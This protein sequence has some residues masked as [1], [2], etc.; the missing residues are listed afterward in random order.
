MKVSKGVMTVI[1][2]QKLEGN[3]YRLLGTTV[4]GGVVVAESK[5]DSTVLWHMLLG[6]MSK[7][8]MIELHKRNLFKGVKTCELDFCKYCILEK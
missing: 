5:S 6:H 7:C 1:K 3:I 2:G 4:V 8:E